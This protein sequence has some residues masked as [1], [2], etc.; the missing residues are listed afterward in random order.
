MISELP[1]I[2]IKGCRSGGGKGLTNGH[3]IDSEFM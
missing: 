1:E 3:K 2:N